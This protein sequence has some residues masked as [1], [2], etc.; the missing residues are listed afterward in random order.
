[1]ILKNFILG[2]FVNLNF[3]TGY[4]DFMEE[5]MNQVFKRTSISCHSYTYFLLVFMLVDEN[6][7]LLPILQFWL[8]MKPKIKRFPIEKICVWLDWIF[9][10][11]DKNS[12]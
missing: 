4:H 5:W 3:E 10:F 7:S 12:Y 1:M 8:R 6:Y 11:F 2:K 9:N